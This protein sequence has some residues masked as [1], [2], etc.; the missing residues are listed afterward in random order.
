VEFRALRMQ[1]TP[2]RG[3]ALVC[4]LRAAAG[5]ESDWDDW[6]VM[7]AGIPLPMRL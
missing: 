2:E 3:A 1:H 5:G 6:Q 7:V 4:L